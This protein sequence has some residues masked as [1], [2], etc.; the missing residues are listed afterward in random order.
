MHE[1]LFRRAK[2]PENETELAKVSSSRGT[3]F[4]CISQDDSFTEDSRWMDKSET[5][6][7]GAKSIF[8]GSVQSTP[9]NAV[10]IVHEG[11]FSTPMRDS[12][13]PTKIIGQDDWKDKVKA[14]N[15]A[16]RHGA[17]SQPE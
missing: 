10:K 9:E 15:G 8:A 2:I 14:D 17:T 13:P 4:R 16:C 11:K 12:K 7:N 1:E 3:G 5:V 6:E